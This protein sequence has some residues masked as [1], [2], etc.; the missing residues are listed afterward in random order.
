M[1]RAVAAMRAETAASLEQ[2]NRRTNILLPAMTAVLGLGL[3]LSL[4]GFVAIRR[5]NRDR[6]R[7]D[8]RLARHVR[9]AARLR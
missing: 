3:G 9:E 1:E 2:L 6:H 8:I 5:E 4:L 7:T